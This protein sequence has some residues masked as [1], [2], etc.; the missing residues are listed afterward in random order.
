MARCGIVIQVFIVWGLETA[1]DMGNLIWLPKYW[2]TC[3][4]SPWEKKCFFSHTHGFISIIAS[5]MAFVSFPLNASPFFFSV[6]LSPS[7][8]SFQS[9][10]WSFIMSALQFPLTDVALRGLIFPFPCVLNLFHS[11]SRP[12]HEYFFVAEIVP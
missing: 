10:I 2:A 12:S 8:G 6:C 3:L 1:A 7:H 5:V 11:L 4:F 9:P